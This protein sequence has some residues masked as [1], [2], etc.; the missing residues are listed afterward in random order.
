[1]KKRLFLPFFIKLF[2]CQLMLTKKYAHNFSSTLIDKK[3]RHLDARHGNNMQIHGN[4]K[5]RHAET[6]HQ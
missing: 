1:M 4:D 2:F 5:K 6:T 3:I